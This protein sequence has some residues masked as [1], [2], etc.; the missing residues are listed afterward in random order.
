MRLQ[1][2]YGDKEIA[3]SSEAGILYDPDET[4]NL[5]KTLSELGIQP[6]SFLT[7]TD[8]DDVEPF[9]NV[10]LHIET[11]HEEQPDKPIKALA[12]RLEIPKKPQQEPPVETK[13]P[14]SN[15]V[16][17]IDDESASKRKRPLEEEAGSPEAKKKKLDA[18]A[19][20]KGKAALVIDDDGGA[21]LIDD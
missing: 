13:P 5:P 12:E 15:G 6:D 2:R 3:V 21:I 1:L 11:P 16:V 4:E 7:V 8:E 18:T 20:A 10:V 9:V 14:E 19:A 17:I